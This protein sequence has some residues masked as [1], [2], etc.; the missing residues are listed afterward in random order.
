MSHVL[1]AKLTAVKSVCIRH[2]YLLSF[3]TH[4]I[5]LLPNH[6]NLFDEVNDMLVVLRLHNLIVFFSYNKK[7]IVIF[8]IHKDLDFLSIVSWHF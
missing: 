2:N 1:S 6:S 5:N 3:A 7:I 8:H 4:D